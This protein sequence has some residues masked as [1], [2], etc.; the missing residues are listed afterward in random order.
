MEK[1]M[2]YDF[3]FKLKFLK[4]FYLAGVMPLP[5]TFRWKLKLLG[6]DSFD[7]GI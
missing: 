5:P 6:N 1:I 2:K 3:E 7:Y 4:Y